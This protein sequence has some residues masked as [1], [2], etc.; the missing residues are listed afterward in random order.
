MT[1][2][3]GG[4]GVRGGREEGGR[5]GYWTLMG[6]SAVAAF[7]ATIQLYVH[8]RLRG[9]SGKCNFCS[10]TQ[11]WPVKRTCGTHRPNSHPSPALDKLLVH[12]CIGCGMHVGLNVF[13]K[14]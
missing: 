2:G 4:E 10:A 13:S 14:F 5:A 11:C 3:E 6:L 9:G 12:M 7:A 1:L 8:C